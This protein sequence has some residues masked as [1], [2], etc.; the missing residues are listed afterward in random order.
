MFAAIRRA[1]ST[2]GNHAPPGLQTNPANLA[3]FHNNALS[4]GGVRLVMPVT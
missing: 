4:N 2:K 3:I 1:R